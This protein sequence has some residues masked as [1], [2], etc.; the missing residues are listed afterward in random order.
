MWPA[1][2]WLIVGLALIAAEVLSG[3]FVLLMLGG[4]ALAAGRRCRCSGSGSPVVGGV[5]FAIA[6]GAAAVRGAPG[7]APP[8][9]PGHRPTAA[10]AHRGAGRQDRRRRSPGSTGTAAGHD[11]RRAVVGAGHSTGPRRDRGGRHGD[12]HA[13]S[14]GATALVVAD[15]L[16]D[17]HQGAQPDRGCRIPATAG[18]R[19]GG[20]LA[21]GSILLVVVVLLVCVVISCQGGADH[22]AGHRRRRRATGPV[23]GRRGP[24]AGVP[25]AVRRQDPRADRPARAGG[26]PSRRS[27]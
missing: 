26:A 14:R 9:R 15:E 19:R 21:E 11:R 10:A 3:E 5:M 27:R 24:G 18:G 6:V 1:V 16:I 8:A 20:P 12:G 2:I 4:G 23:Q 13:T 22:P 7:A 17:E 25:G